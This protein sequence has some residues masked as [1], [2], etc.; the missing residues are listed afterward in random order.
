MGCKGLVDVRMMDLQDLD[1]QVVVPN[2]SYR[3]SPD[4]SKLTGIY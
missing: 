4:G 2:K 1:G 3:C